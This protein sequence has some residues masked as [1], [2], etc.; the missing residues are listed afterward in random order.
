MIRRREFTASVVAAAVAPTVLWA[1][2]PPKIAR[3]RFFQA[4]DSR[5]KST[6]DEFQAFRQKLEDLGWREGDNLHLDL[7]QI[8]ADPPAIA[9]AV[10]DT[11][12]LKPDVV[13]S[14][15]STAI[16]QIEQ[17]APDLRI[18]FYSITDPI[19]QGLVQSLA[20]P[21]GNATGFSAY[22][23]S[24]G[25]KWVSLLKQ[26][27]P[28][29]TRAAF[30]YQPGN[31]PY[32]GGMLESITPAAAS[33]GITLVDSPFKSGDELRRLIASFAQVPNGAV[34]LPPGSWAFDFIQAITDLEARYRLPSIHASTA[35]VAS[36]VLI[37]YGA[38]RVEQT[39]QAA[40]YVDRI[41]KGEKPG[42]LPVQNPTKYDLAINL[43]TARS[44]GLT[45]PQSLLVAADQLV[46]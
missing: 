42:D 44:L 20:H 38:D 1:Q 2:Q 33:V 35:N 29:V 45:V 3:V 41:L 10:A 25:G 36:G 37:A 31:A 19:S 8:A 11:I 9:A 4:G 5:S 28:A 15:T 21:G 18:V 13:V 27:A 17:K 16:A 24:L 46:E 14:G 43:K 30:L 32:I 40:S 6:Q 39:R 23:F 22:E 7:P 12:N 34:I 26:I